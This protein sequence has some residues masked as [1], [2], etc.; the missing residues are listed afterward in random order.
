MENE[1]LLMW[2]V[3]V[4]FAAIGAQTAVM[5]GFFR[6]HQKRLDKISN[7]L[8]KALGR[9]SVMRD[10]FRDVL[11]WLRRPFGK[12]DIRRSG[13]GAGNAEHPADGAQGGASRP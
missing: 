10:M 2:F 8:A 9:L 5:I 1:E 4:L 12:A 3:G 6:Y 11:G 7:R 13:K